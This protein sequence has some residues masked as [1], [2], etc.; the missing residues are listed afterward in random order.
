MLDSWCIIA[1]FPRKC[2][3]KIGQD[4]GL[5]RGRNQKAILSIARCL[6]GVML[7]CIETYAD[8]LVGYLIS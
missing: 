8:D 3:S 4:E 7:T 5:Q 2:A 1:D 6:Q